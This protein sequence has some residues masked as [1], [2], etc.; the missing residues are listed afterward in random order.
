MFYI[1]TAFLLDG[2]VCMYCKVDERYANDDRIS[3]GYIR[4]MTNS[5]LD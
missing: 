1:C 4:L 2:A 5:I 3:Q